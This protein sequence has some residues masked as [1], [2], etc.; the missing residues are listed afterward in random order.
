MNVTLTIKLR[1]SWRNLW[2]GKTVVFHK[3]GIADFA[4]VQRTVHEIWKDDHVQDV[5]VT[6][7]P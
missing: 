7:T 2:L 4:E 5:V 6:V 1:P 3:D